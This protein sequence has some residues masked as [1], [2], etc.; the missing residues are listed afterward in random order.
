MSLPL[1][2]SMPMPIDPI[3]IFSTFLIQMGNRKDGFTAAQKELIDH[4]IGKL[5]ILF[6]MF[7]FST[8]NF[9]WSVTLLV[10]YYLTVNMLLNENHDLNIFSRNWLKMKGFVSTSEG[11]GDEDKNS[12]NLLDIYYENIEAMSQPTNK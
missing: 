5:L 10:L 4:P 9:M 11:E 6:G 3:N 2:I 7:Y 12:Y 1:P 8:R